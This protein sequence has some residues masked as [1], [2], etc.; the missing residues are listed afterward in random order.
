MNLY[1]NTED[2]QLLNHSHGTEEEEEEEEEEEDGDMKRS[3]I[4]ILNVEAAE[5]TTSLNRPTTSSRRKQSSYT[6]ITVYP[7]DGSV[8]SITNEQDVR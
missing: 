7:E 6:S 2:V 8:S 4:A 5:S 3:E 1:D